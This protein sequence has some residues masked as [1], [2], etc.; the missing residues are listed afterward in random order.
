[1]M[2]RL[3]FQIPNQQNKECFIIGVLPHIHSALIQKKVTAQYK[4]I[5]INMKL[6]ASSIRDNIGTV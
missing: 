4:A 1:V 5:E 2:G 3:T 6:E